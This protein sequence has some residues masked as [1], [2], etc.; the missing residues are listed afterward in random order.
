[1]YDSFDNTYQVGA[2]AGTDS[3]CFVCNDRYYL[4]WSVIL[5]CVSVHWSETYSCTWL[6]DEIHYYQENEFTRNAYLCVLEE[7]VTAEM[8]V[9]TDNFEPNNIK[10]T[11]GPQAITISNPVLQSSLISLVILKT[12]Y[13]LS[14]HSSCRG[15]CRRVHTRRG[16]L[17]KPCNIIAL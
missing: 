14:S 10:S 12:D 2:T 1:M 8:D 7:D 5:C 6:D 13:C 17:N 9:K 16:P 4:Y 15:L 11:M 3:Q